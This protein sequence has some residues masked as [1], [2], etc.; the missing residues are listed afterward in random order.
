M[1]EAKGG[2]RAGI[3]RQDKCLGVSLEE[4]RLTF[5]ILEEKKILATRKFRETE[6][7]ASLSHLDGQEWRESFVMKSFGLWLGSLGSSGFL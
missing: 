7:V 1:T 5:I 6:G 2:G 4:S 3:D